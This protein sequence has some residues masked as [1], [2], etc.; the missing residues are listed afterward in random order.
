MKKVI[1]LGFF[2]IGCFLMAGMVSAQTTF[3]EYNSFMF[4]EDNT[5]GEVGFPPSDPGDILTAVGFVANLGP[6]LEWGPE[7]DMGIVELTIVLTDLVSTGE[8]DMGNGLFYIIYTGGTIDIMAD[9]FNDPGYTAADYG[10]EP[11]NATAPAT[12]WDGEQ[13]L[14]GEFSSFWM[15]Y[16]P[17]LHTGSFE[18]QFVFTGGTQFDPAGIPDGFTFAG[19]VDPFAAQVPIGYDLEA[20]GQITFD[21]SVPNEPNTWGQVKNLYR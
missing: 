16:Y 19:D 9:P 11:P 21:Q 15:T 2:A 12:F 3:L 5:P 18:G 7:W 8:Q 4:E 14:H 17:M 6:G 1:I 13:Y 10:E 20:V